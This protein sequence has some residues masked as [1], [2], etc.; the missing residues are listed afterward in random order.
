MAAVNDKPVLH[1]DTVDEWDQWLA[2][3]DAPDGVRLRLRKKATTLPGITYPEALDVALCHGWID[4]QAGSLDEN[5]HLQV[6]TPRRA[7]SV[8]SQRNRDHIERLTAEGRMRPAGLEQVALAKADGRWDAAYR[9]KDAE[10]PADLRAALDASPTASTMFDSLNA[11]NRWAILFRLGSLKRATTREA[12]IVTY[13]AMLEKGET[14]YP[15]A[16]K[17]G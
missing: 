17:K 14:I 7:R 10:V 9:Q 15:Q 12:K 6:F 8:W 2:T 4:G 16:P 5:Y 1:V 3:A 11:Q 13:V